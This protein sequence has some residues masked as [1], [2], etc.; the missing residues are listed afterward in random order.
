MP[1][2]VDDPAWRGFA[3]VDTSAAARAGLHRRPLADTFADVLAWERAHPLP[4]PRAAGVGDATER[5]LVAA[6]PAA[7]AT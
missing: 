2:W 7:P 5:R 3:T 6:R 4:H 1:L